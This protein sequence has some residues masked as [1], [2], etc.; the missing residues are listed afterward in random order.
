MGLHR[1]DPHACQGRTC[2]EFSRQ[3]ASCWLRQSTNDLFDIN[4]EILSEITFSS[5][6]QLFTLKSKLCTVASERGGLFLQ[7]LTELLPVLV[8]R[9]VVALGVRTIIGVAALVHV[10]RWFVFDERVVKIDEGQGA[11]TSDG[12]IAVTSWFTE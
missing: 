5:L 10:F 4:I 1:A 6:L 7:K 8:T 12:N 2:R 9:A 3:V 11:I